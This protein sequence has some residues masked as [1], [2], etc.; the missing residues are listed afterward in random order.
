M[1]TYSESVDSNYSAGTWSAFVIG[2]AVGAA[3]ALILAPASGRDT[4]AYLRRRGDELGHE[5]MERG[6]ELGRDAME[7]GRE[8][9]RDAME[10]GRESLRTQSE[11]VKSAVASGW[12]RAGN[13]IS[14]AREE[15][16]AAYREARESFQQSDSG[17]ARTSYRTDSPRSVE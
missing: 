4:R 13:A 14:N 6:R 9:S 17:M 2:A 15:G 1:N 10:V 5:A 11:R 3:A 8:L 7:R 12:E 16:E